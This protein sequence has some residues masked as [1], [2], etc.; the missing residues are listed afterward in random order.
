MASP[1]SAVCLSVCDRYAERTC[2]ETCAFDVFVS[3][4]RI[5][6]YKQCEALTRKQCEAVSTCP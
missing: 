4:R 2:G 6:L 1:A 5:T 3:L